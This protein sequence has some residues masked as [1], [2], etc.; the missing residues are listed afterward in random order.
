MLQNDISL[1]QNKA[2]SEYCCHVQYQKRVRLLDLCRHL[3]R[4]E[5]LTHTSVT[6]DT[7]VVVD[8][9]LQEGLVLFQHLVAH[10]RDVVKERLILHLRNKNSHQHRKR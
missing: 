7:I 3:N 9:F 1:Q 5:T 8:E 4:T 2:S 6:V 10:V